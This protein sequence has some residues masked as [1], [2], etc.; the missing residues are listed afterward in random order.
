MT[1]TKRQ[2]VTP[3][4]IINEGDSFLPGEG[5]VKR[6]GKIIAQK[7]GLAEEQNNLI[8]VIPLSGVYTSRRG[9]SVIGKV[10][11][12]THN[13]WIIDIGAPENAFL[14][15]ME[16]PKYVN[17]DN[18]EE[19][20]EIGDM[21]FAKI[22]Y[23]NKRG[24]DLTLKSRG[25]G[26]IYEGMVFKVN[27]HKVPRIIGKEGS[28]INLI[29]EK[30]N[31]NITVGQNGYVWIKAEKVEDELK[32]KEAILFIVEKSFV[33]GLTDEVNKFFDEKEKKE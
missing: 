17:K 10:E 19:V 23:I 7:F 28:M 21:V 6:E 1:E 13:G 24:I 31:T 16:V 14:T 5:T 8:K 32:A 25:L 20:L 9:N 26:K 18:L 30:T 22:A 2:V 11:N 29:K 27:P 3:G 15:I 12:I 33:S 4:E